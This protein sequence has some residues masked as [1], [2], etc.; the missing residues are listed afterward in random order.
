MFDTT[1]IVKRSDKEKYVYSGYGITFDGKGSCSSRN[2]YTR[3][4]LIFGVD[5]TSSFHTDNLR[6]HFITLGEG[7]TFGISGNIDPSETKFSINFSKAKTKFGLS[8]H[9]KG[10]NS[11]LF[12]NGK[13][14]Y[15]F[16]DSSKNV[17][18]PTQF[19]LGSISNNFSVYYEVIHKSDILNIQNYLMNKNGIVQIKC[20]DSLKNFYHCNDACWL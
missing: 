14:I 11:Y 10:D 9:Y 4:V 8:L 13:E 18:F 19:C 12:V 17:N 20:L 16:K 2:E 7:D 1:T 6:N 5:N 3:N 15:K